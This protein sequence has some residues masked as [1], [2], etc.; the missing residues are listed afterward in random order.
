MSLVLISVV[1]GHTFDVIQLE[2]G[3][4]HCLD[5]AILQVGCVAQL[6]CATGIKA[7]V[8]TQSTCGLSSAG[9]CEAQMP[10]WMGWVPQKARPSPSPF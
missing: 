2:H 4:E 1:F 7:L 8:V 3:H 5:L 6:C 9:T 10:L